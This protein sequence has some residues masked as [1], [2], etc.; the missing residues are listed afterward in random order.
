MY[1]F[2]AIMRSFSLLQE[3]MLPY[4]GVLITNLAAKL[5]LVSKVKAF[6]NLFN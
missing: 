4:V 6:C 5:I 1:Y 3:A 2:A